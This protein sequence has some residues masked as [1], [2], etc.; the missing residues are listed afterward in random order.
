[1]LGIKVRKQLF[2]AGTNERDLEEQVDTLCRAVRAQQGLILTIRW[3]R[4]PED[5]G[6]RASIVYQVP[7]VQQIDTAIDASLPPRR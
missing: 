6:H 5:I 3:P 4:A 2:V 7:L 1:M